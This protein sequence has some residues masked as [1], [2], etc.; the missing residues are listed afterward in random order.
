MGYVWNFIFPGFGTSCITIFEDNEGA[1]NLAQSPVCTSNLKYIDVRH[2]FLRQL[3]FKGELVNTNVE[4]DDQ[5]AD[6]LTKPLDYTAF[7]YHRDFLMNIRC[8]FRVED[9]YILISEYGF[10]S[11]VSPTAFW[12]F[13]IEFLSS[14]TYISHRYGWFVVQ[15]AVYN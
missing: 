11:S 9:S 14:A 3:F 6:I 8:V 15:R 7:C 4:S 1:K 2:H 5:H 10:K 12:L 13:E